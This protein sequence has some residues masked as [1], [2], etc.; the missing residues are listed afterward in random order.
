MKRFLFSEMIS[1]YILLSGI[2]LSQTSI[3]VEIQKLAS[4]LLENVPENKQIISGLGIPY[5]SIIS[6]NNQ[7]Q[8]GPDLLPLELFVNKIIF[9]F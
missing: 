8:R 4:Y 3:L 9:D 5:L 2:Q 6:K 7:L 1:R